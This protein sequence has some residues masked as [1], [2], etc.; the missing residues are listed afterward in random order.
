MNK[1]KTL[2][3][4]GATI[5]LLST[6]ATLAGTVN[7]ENVTTFAG[8]SPALAEEVNGNFSEL[9]TQVNDNDERVVLLE[10]VLTVQVDSN[11]DRIAALEAQ[12]EALTGASITVAGVNGTYDAYTT[13][14]A[15]LG[16]PVGVGTGNFI[17]TTLATE[18]AQITFDGNGNCSFTA[19]EITN[20]TITSVTEVVPNPPLNDE[21]IVSSTGETE[22][23]SDPSDCTYTV[24]ASALLTLTYLDNLGFP[25]GDSD[26]IQ[27]TPD[28]NFGAGNFAEADAVDGGLTEYQVGMFAVVKRAGSGN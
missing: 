19:S 6:S 7:N 25:S 1:Q 16:G 10:D 2:Q 9:T 13:V 17:S 15:S 21:W 4:L 8:G 11:E 3:T 20:F 5:V 18:A 24:S 28:L 22:I 27:M 23:E 26:S 14:T 12:I